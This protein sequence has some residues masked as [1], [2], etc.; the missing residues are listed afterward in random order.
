MAVVAAA[1]RN[2]KKS[3]PVEL[4]TGVNNDVCTVYKRTKKAAEMSSSQGSKL[5]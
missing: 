2:Q 4:T 3:C 1:E 5:T